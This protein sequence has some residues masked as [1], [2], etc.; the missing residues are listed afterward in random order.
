MVTS[1]MARL[2]WS[3]FTDQMVMMMMTKNMVLVIYDQAKGYQITRDTAN[4]NE[5]EMKKL[6]IWTKLDHPDGDE[7]MNPD[8][9]IAKTIRTTTAMPKV[10]SDW[11]AS[12]RNQER[13]KTKTKLSPNFSREFFFLPLLL[14]FFDISH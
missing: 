14:S 1:G 2:T 6:K 8:H 9:Q 12:L 11:L 4:P 7:G 3:C 5:K 10:S 13:T